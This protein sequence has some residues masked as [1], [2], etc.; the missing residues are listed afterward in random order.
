[1]IQIKDAQ[2]DNYPILTASPDNNDGRFAE[3]ILQLRQEIESKPAEPPQPRD[4]Q[5]PLQL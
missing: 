2:N 5:A 1:M 3:A 4:Q